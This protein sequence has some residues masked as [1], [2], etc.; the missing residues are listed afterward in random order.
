LSA[1]TSATDS[2]LPRSGFQYRTLL[3]NM[4]DS[5]RESN[6]SRQ[7]VSTHLAPFAPGA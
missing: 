1:G 5:I 6:R 4:N 2:P 7:R 3:V